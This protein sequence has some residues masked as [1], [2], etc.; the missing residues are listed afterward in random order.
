MRAVLNYSKFKINDTTLII[1][2]LEYIKIKVFDILEIL[3]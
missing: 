3:K 1:L 2:P